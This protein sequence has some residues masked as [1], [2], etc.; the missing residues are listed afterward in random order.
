MY[1]MLNGC[2]ETILT[3]HDI[4]LLLV[5]LA[6]GGTQGVRLDEP[7]WL[8]RILLYPLV[9]ARRLWTNNDKMIFNHRNASVHCALHL[10][11][12]TIHGKLK[13]MV[14]L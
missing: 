9:L 13:L 4:L 6:G 14:F 1:L 10:E 7:Q 5:D 8:E 3:S 2:M 12:I 11:I